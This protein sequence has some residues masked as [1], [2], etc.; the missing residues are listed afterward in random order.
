MMK[1]KKAIYT[2]SNKTK[3]QVTQLQNDI[4]NSIKKYISTIKKKTKPLTNMQV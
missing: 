3:D 4:K 1:V 2:L